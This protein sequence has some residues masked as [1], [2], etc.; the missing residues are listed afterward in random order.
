VL[1]DTDRLHPDVRTFLEELLREH[2]GEDLRVLAARRSQEPSE[3][4]RE[5]LTRAMRELLP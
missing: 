2:P 3:E 4:E 1:T 5:R